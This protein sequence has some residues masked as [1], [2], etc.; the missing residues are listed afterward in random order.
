MVL[1]AVDV[2]PHVRRG[3]IRVGAG[4]CVLS[5]ALR[6]EVI[7]SAQELGNN[8]SRTDGGGDIPLCSPG[9]NGQ[10]GGR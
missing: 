8:V 4:A 6:G 10:L 9:A 7:A 2:A 5:G 1:E 3:R